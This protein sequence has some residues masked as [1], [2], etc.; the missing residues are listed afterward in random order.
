MKQFKSK[1]NRL[2]RNCALVAI[3]AVVSIGMLAPSAYAECKLDPSVEV[4][5][6]A[7][8]NGAKV[9]YRPD[10]K[11][12][13]DPGTNISGYMDDL[14]IKYKAQYPAAPESTRPAS[15]PYILRENNGKIQ[16]KT[17]EERRRIV[18]TEITLHLSIP[19]N[20]PN[21]KKDKSEPEQYPRAYYFCDTGFDL[22]TCQYPPNRI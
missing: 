20:N 12:R 3:A 19:K 11:F 1:T 22:F 2:K 18:G 14:E 10:Q 7:V 9:S 6:N 5:E 17:S 15:N 8:H 16:Y 21:V 4:P 13:C